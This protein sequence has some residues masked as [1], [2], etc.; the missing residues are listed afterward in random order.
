MLD[1]CSFEQPVLHRLLINISYMGIYS[2]YIGE[3]CIYCIKS[4]QIFQR[5]ISLR[6]NESNKRNEWIILYST[7]FTQQISVI[8]VKQIIKNNWEWLQEKFGP[9]N[10]L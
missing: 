8:K 1:W 4:T 9:S 6:C 10:T 3:T 2:L 5:R 7:S